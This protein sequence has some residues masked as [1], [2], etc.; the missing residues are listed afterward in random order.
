MA[1]S[2][3]VGYVRRA[4]HLLH[5]ILTV[6]QKLVVVPPMVLDSPEEAKPQLTQS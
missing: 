5:H 3:R 6:I 2:Q 4:N 1:I